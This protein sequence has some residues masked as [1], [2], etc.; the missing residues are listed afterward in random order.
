MASTHPTVG[1]MLRWSRVLL[2]RSG[3]RPLRVRLRH[4]G[5]RPADVALASYPRSGNTWIRFLLYQLTTGQA[6]EWPAVNAAIP[7]VGEHHQARPLLADGGRLFKTHENDPRY[8]QRAIYLVRDP[9]DVVLSEH[10][11]TRM[12]GNFDGELDAFVETFVKGQVHGL[13]TWAAHARGWLEASRNEGHV[14]VV[15]YEDLRAEPHPQVTRVAR[16]LDLPT[17]EETIARA[18]ADNTIERMR[19]KEAGAGFQKTDQALS[20][21]SKGQVEGWRQKLTPEAAAAIE[22]ACAPVLDALGYSRSA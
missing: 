18:I 13:G 3:L 12:F 10:R 7:Y 20:H 6:G 15:R 21:V 4:R 5:L 16:F 1:R 2:E 17:D 8:Y 19:R 14:L 22:V 9:R 11:H